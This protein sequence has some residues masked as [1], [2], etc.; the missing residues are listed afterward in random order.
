MLYTR[1]PG[2]A[3]YRDV[4]MSTADALAITAVCAFLLTGTL[5]VV[6]RVLNFRPLVWLGVLSYSLYLWQQP[7][8]QHG[9]KLGPAFELPWNMLIVVGCALASYFLVERPF[10]ILKAKSSKQRA[11]DDS[12]PGT[13]GS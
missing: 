13:V 3:L 7:F 12:S 1:R 2:V 9:R 11:L 6:T 4:F 8:T 10:L 5:G